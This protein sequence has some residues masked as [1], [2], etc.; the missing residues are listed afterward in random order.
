MYLIKAYEIEKLPDVQNLLG[1]CYYE[2]GNYEQ[3]KTIFL[4]M[5]EK[6]PMNVNILLNVAKCFDKLGDAEKA[7]EY[8]EKTVDLFAECEE[9]QELI[10]K[11]S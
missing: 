5:L 9:A 6:T 4:N 11:L 8:A 2:L 10:R 1:L 7:L 3:A